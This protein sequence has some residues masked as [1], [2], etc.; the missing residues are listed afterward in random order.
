MQVL[1]STT[2]P[3]SSRVKLLAMTPGR[4]W[5]QSICAPS[6]GEHVILWR[7]SCV[8]PGGTRCSPGWMGAPLWGK[9]WRLYCKLLYLSIRMK[10]NAHSIQKLTNCSRMPKWK[11]A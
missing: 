8:R 3:G 1:A 11:S 5:R 9:I 7:I 10:Q 2:H 6:L 4:K